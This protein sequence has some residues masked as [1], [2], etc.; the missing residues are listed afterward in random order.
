MLVAKLNVRKPRAIW[1]IIA[2]T[3]GRIRTTKGA[4]EQATKQA[5]R[6][7]QSAVGAPG[8]F[9]P[10][11]SAI[12]H[13]YSENLMLDKGRGQVVALVD[14][15]AS[16]IM[17]EDGGA[18]VQW[19]IGPGCR[20][21]PK[22]DTGLVSWIF[23]G[24]LMRPGDW[25]SVVAR[26]NRDA[27]PTACPTHFNTAYTRY[28]TDL[29]DTEFRVVG[30]S[31][32][33]Q[34]ISRRLDVI[35]SEHYGGDDIA[36]AEHLERFYLAR[37]SQ[38]LNTDMA[39]T[40]CPTTIVNAPVEIVWSLLTR[41]EKWGDFYDVRVTSVEPAGP[42]V[43]GQTVFAESGPRLLHLA[44]EFCFTKIDAANYELGLDVKFPFGVTVRED[45]SCVPIGPDQCGVNYHC[46]FAFPAG[47]RGTV[48]RFL[49]SRE[50]NSGPV[51]SLS[52]LR[53]AAEERYG[54]SARQVT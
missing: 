43:V 23:F 38:M 29:I 35:V 25:Q 3:I 9:K 31:K 46:G 17:T 15:W 16:A 49:M 5:T 22:N 41:P 20:T 44:L 47:W 36:H 10:S 34:I 19:F 48:A 52:R 32:G 11:T 13:A 51:D 53:R 14:G 6:F 40:S 37:E 27:S 4:Q 12:L 39:H 8:L 24:G 1:P 45:L 30:P 21:A 18:G 54:A 7:L 26:L 33:A 28:R 2:S 50:L 42:A